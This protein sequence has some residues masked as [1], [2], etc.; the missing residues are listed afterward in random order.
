MQFYLSNPDLDQQIA[1]IRQTI[2]L[3]MNGV[4]SDQMKSMGISYKQNYGVAIPRIREIAKQ[5]TPNHDL[6]QR[7]W[8]LKIRET[9]ILATLLEPIEIFTKEQAYEWVNEVTHTELAEQTAM[10]LFCKLPYAAELATEWTVSGNNCWMQ[11]TG[12]LTAARIY[13]QLS[14]PTD[15]MILEHSFLLSNTDNLHL[16]K[17]I[18]LYLGRMARN[19]DEIRQRIKNAIKPFE[20]STNPGQQFIYNEV[21]GE[22]LFLEEI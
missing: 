21:M 3:S 16:Y 9:M 20:N 15:N 4:V 14:D 6:A 2:R 13:N 19:N 22:I 17:A 10:N 5:Y 8:A 1:K 18:S 11:I 12:F 7:L